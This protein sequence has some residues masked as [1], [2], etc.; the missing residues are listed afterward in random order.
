LYANGSY[1]IIDSSNIA[2]GY[3]NSIYGNAANLYY[4]NIAGGRNNCIYNSSC[5]FIAGGC[6]NYTNF[7][8]TFL[9]GS[10][11]SATRANYTY[12]NNLSSQGIL[13]GTCITLSQD[14]T[15][16]INP[17][18]ASGTFLVVN[19]NGINKA[20]QLWDYSS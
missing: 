8:N 17:V 16:F 11:L 15:T 20:L 3:N 2:G 14:P 5:S 1:N 6:N 19:I 18:T 12:V 13:A 4:S 9:L 7:D 10:G